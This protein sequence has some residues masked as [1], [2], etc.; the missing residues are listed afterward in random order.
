ML[1]FIRRIS[2][3]Y[4]LHVTLL[5]L[6][7][8]FVQAQVGSTAIQSFIGS[9]KGA[10][11]FPDLHQWKEVRS[12][13]GGETPASIYTLTLTLLNKKKN[14]DTESDFLTGDILKPRRDQ[15]YS[16]RPFTVT[17]YGGGDQKKKSESGGNSSDGKK[18]EKKG[19]ASSTSSTSS[20]K[21]V[22]PPI[23]IT[24]LI[25]KLKA[26]ESKVRKNKKIVN[27]SDN[28]DKFNRLLKEWIE[29]YPL[30]GNI[31]HISIINGKP[32]AYPKAAT[33]L[34]L[35][36]TRFE[37]EMKSGE[38]VFI[39][40]KKHLGVDVDL[41]KKYIEEYYRITLPDNL[42][43]AEYQRI[44]DDHDDQYHVWHLI[45]PRSIQPLWRYFAESLSNLKLGESKIYIIMGVNHHLT[46]FYIR[47]P[48]D[49]SYRIL[50]ADSM[51]VFTMGD[52]DTT[53]SPTAQL[54]VLALRLFF[55]FK[56]SDFK[57]YLLPSSRQ[58]DE[59]TCMSML[60]EDVKNLLE[61]PVIPDR[62]EYF[63]K[64]EDAY[65]YELQLWSPVISDVVEA[66]GKLQVNGKDR[67]NNLLAQFMSPV[68]LKLLREFMSHH[69]SVEDNQNAYF[70][71]DHGFYELQKFPPE[72][73]HLTQGTDNLER[74]TKA[75]PKEQRNEVLTHIEENREI[76][77]SDGSQQNGRNLS[78]FLLWMALVIEALEH[79][80]PDTKQR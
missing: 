9:G 21:K 5:L 10:L 60:F 23:P 73:L 42:T 67:Q 6:L 18:E 61:H 38:V 48:K 68:I 31:L 16:E 55:N 4:F 62:H 14:N 77:P 22:S 51:R 29:Q 3:A 24:K 25:K 27:Q 15:V 75:F 39:N 64:K 35:L 58:V 66:E 34:S 46:A 2:V 76:L 74:L 30:L 20:Q 65:K 43:T 19:T 8:V 11:S 47:K 26:I 41:L 56:T 12:L 44:I 57:F 78:S 32:R 50:V 45:V 69:M 28:I 1:T 17:S 63:I 72:F 52:S 59:N 79:N 33:V 54:A 13:P 40:L 37:K 7:P 49:N 53:F 36:Q 70:S 80:N 71:N